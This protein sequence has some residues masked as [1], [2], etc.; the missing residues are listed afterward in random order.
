VEEGVAEAFCSGFYSIQIIFCIAEYI[1]SHLLTPIEQVK[2]P[3]KSST[4]VTS[5]SHKTQ[6]GLFLV[7]SNQELDIYNWKQKNGKQ[8]GRGHGMV[9]RKVALHVSFTV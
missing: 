8:E 4:L 6:W 3:M 5:W 2:V 1:L 7:I 9:C